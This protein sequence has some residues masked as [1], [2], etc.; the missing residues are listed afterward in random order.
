MN[1]ALSLLWLRSLLW[2]KSNPWPRNF[3]KT[4][5]LKIKRGKKIYSTNIKQKK[6]AAI[7]ISDKV[8]FKIRI[9]VRD[10]EGHNTMIKESVLQEGIKFLICV[11]IRIREAR[12]SCHGSGVMSLTSIHEDVGSIPGLT[13]QVKDTTLWRAVVQVANAAWNLHCRGCG[14]GWQLWLQFDSQP[15][16]LHMLQA[17]P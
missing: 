6:A 8:D 11:S 15:R 14:I 9:V 2:C 7:L 5:S 10:R 17:Q 12:S 1:L 16:N 4:Y 3:Q 13:Q